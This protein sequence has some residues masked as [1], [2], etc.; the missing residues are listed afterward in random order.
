MPGHILWLL[1]GRK[2]GRV[3]D[4]HVVLGLDLVGPVGL[5]VGLQTGHGVK[6]DVT[7]PLHWC[8]LDCLV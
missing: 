4:D 2:K 3:A 6:E 1:V 8:Q 5:E 7:G